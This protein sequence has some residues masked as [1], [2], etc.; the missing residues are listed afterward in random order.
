MLTARPHAV[1]MRGISKRFGPVQA[2]HAV[3]LTVEAGTVHGIVGEN[4]AGKSTLMSIL[5]GF[6]QA[7]A[8]TIAIDGQQVEIR[9]AH[10]AIACGIGM[11]H[12]HFMLV[13]SLSALDNVMLGSEPHWQL[14][15][16]RQRVRNDLESLMERTGLQVRLEL[17]V[18]TLPV[19][20][21]QRLEIL[22]ALYRGARI[23]ILD[24]PTAV[25]TPQETD[26][27]FDTLRSL[28]DSGTTLLLIT[29]KLK[30]IMALCQQ[31]TVMRQG[32]VVL[33]CA[34]EHTSLDGLAQAMVGRQ[35]SLMQRVTPAP[36]GAEISDPQPQESNLQDS[37]EAKV[38]LH[39]QD[40]H[41]RD[42]LGVVRLGGVNLSLHA[43]EIVGVA[44]VSGNGQS[45]LLDALSGLLVPDTGVL[46]LGGHTFIAPRWID[47]AQARA[48]RLA[49]VPEDRHRRGLV[50][51]FEAWES[52]V[53]G[54]QDRYARQGIMRR[55]DMH[56]AT[57]Q[58]MKDYDVRPPQT[59]WRSSRFSGG[60]QQKLILAR[61]A[62]AQPQVML[63]GQPTRGVDIGAIE[64]IHRR[65][66]QMR[67]AGH[68]L[69]LVSSELEEIMALSDRIVVMNQGRIVGELHAAECT[70][71]ALGRLMG[72]AAAN[73]AD[74]AVAEPS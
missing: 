72:G 54:Y 70:R 36:A 51:P 22:K 25:L 2:N 19:G 9:N 67:A 62:A 49:H 63:V 7:D 37:G 30:E 59:H 13:D 23:L 44:G 4:G 56:Q 46:R 26:V 41:W 29:H 28:R 57:A 66:R 34:I 17:Q 40:L 45:E 18:E 24:E 5:Y 14:Q 53:L 73:G 58:M 61:E 68:A 39:A 60:N 21:R 15:R 65:L 55:H 52:A 71:Q 42:E 32:Q 11:V 33:D 12:Q 74:A 8:G 27:L 48:L 69:L 64:F 47:P 50:L 31:V 1:R 20:E 3:D 16:A 10:D 6:Y 38:L 43:G 35:V